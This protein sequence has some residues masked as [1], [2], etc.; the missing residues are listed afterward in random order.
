MF[1]NK[2]EN[3]KLTAYATVQELI[4]LF[5]PVKAKQALPK[6]HKNLP[7]KRKVWPETFHPEAMTVAQCSGLNYLYGDGL[8]LHSW[9]DMSITIHPDGKATYVTAAQ[10]QINDPFGQHPIDVQAP[11]AWPE[12]TLSLIHILTLPTILLV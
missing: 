4:D 12:Y 6:W 1:W 11:G 9:A 5:P 7:K 8:I 10:K 3:L 2:K